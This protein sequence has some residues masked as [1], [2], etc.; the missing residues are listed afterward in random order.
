MHVFYLLFY[1]AFKQAKAIKGWYNC[2]LASVLSV[3]NSARL[4]AYDGNKSLY[5]V[6]V[7]V[8]FLSIL[9]CF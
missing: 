7:R 3:R 6:F 4:E 9:N 1:Y 8:A 2:P 5:L